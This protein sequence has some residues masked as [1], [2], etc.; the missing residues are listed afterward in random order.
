MTSMRRGWA[1]S[2]LMHV[3]VLVVGY[4]GLPHIRRPAVM[5]DTPMVVEVTTVAGTTNP[6][7]PPPPPPAK[8]V[9]KETPPPP[10]PPPA[11]PQVAVAAP[12]PPEAKPKPRP[13]PEPLPTPKAEPKPEPK[14]EPVAKTEPKPEPKKVDPPRPSPPS[15]LMAAKPQRK[16]KPPDPFA[17]V[18]RTV[19]ELQRTQQP[20]PETKREP[21]KKAEPPSFESQIARSLASP[22]RPFDATRPLTISEID[23]VRQ[24]I[25]ECWSLPAGAKEAENLVID[26]WVEMNPDGTVREARI[27]DQARVRLDP[28]FRSAAESALRAV[29]NPRCSPL[30]LPREKYDL[31]RTMTLSF[32][33]KE[34]FGT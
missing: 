14:P 9:V 24:Q 10:P 12:P 21:A 34:M 8:P 25:A 11:A 15:P 30:R 22:A 4:L 18:L 26:I 28:F 32:N 31:W 27:Q 23:L 6:P 3:V 5:V 16:P 29:L 19:E 20:K 33:P 1:L 7:A 17:S 13:E 2:V